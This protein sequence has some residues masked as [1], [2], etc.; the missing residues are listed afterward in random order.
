M[1]LNRQETTVFDPSNK[2]HRAAVRAFMKRLAWAD[3]P[4]RFGHDPRYGSV[5][6]Q[7]RDKLLIWYMEQD[8]KRIRKPLRLQSVTNDACGLIYTIKHFGDE[9]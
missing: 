9:A 3:S 4:I 5:A 7:V 6:E 2:E 1:L 8:E